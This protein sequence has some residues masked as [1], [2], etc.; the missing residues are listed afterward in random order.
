MQ[1]QL[2]D[3]LL[4]AQPVCQAHGSTHT[5]VGSVPCRGGSAGASL[6]DSRVKTLAQSQRSVHVS[7]TVP[8]PHTPKQ[9][10]CRFG[11]QPLGPSRRC[12]QPPA[13]AVPGAARTQSTEAGGLPPTETQH[14][15]AQQGT[16]L[17]DGRAHAYA[18]VPRGQD[19]T[20]SCD[21]GRQHTPPR[22]QTTP[23]LQRSRLLPVL[24]LL[25]T[26]KRSC[27]QQPHS[28]LPGTWTTAAVY[29]GRRRC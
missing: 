5:A 7:C 1:T 8:M 18:Q 19:S 25:A 16:H 6:T 13:A 4:Q 10:L 29:G 2:P 12:I 14:P 27:S 22:R 28:L 3:A 26:T 23:L 15:D 11:T 17:K 24:Q 21:N 9:T 20:V